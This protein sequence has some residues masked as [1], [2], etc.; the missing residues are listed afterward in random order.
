[1][2]QNVTHIRDLLYNFKRDYGDKVTL[3]QPIQEQTNS[4]TGMRT[5]S[6]NVFHI[7]RATILPRE[8]TRVVFY[9]LSF[10]KANNMFTYAGELDA[11]T[12]MVILDARDLNQPHFRPVEMRDSIYYN[13]ERYEPEKIINLNFNLG[14][15]MALKTIKGSIPYQPIDVHVQH[16]V[17]PCGGVRHE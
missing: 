12:L 3:V 14:V 5:T 8:M 7:Q 13:N 2:A 1:M 11:V 4:V 15:V 17:I 16:T 9:D 6:R 10:L